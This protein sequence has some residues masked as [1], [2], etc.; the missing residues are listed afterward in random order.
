MTLNIIGI[1]LYD[2]DDITV[3]GL[4]LVKK[5]DYVYLESYTSKLGCDIKDLEKLYGKKIIVADRE[6]VESENEIIENAKNNMV[7]FLV[8][9]DVFG[10]T[11]HIDLMQ[12]A[13]VAQI[14]VNIIHNASILT[15]IGQTGLF[16][17]NFGQ[18]TS[19]PFENKN[20]DSPIKV[21]LKNQKA[22]LHTLFLLDLD[23]IKNKYMSF[24]DAI[25]YLIANNISEDELACVCAG[26]GSKDQE[27]LFGTLKELRDKII[28]IY[29][30]SLILPGKLHFVEEEF[31]ESFR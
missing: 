15:A 7:S 24:N 30:H 22:E 5:S 3:K 10:A 12:R 17:Y 8:I 19:I 25:D 4:S 23:P 31:L 29:P 20:V 16:L 1:G 18:I 11:T 13:N 26:M 2:A 14:P 9:G 21:F 28:D 27:I 6:L